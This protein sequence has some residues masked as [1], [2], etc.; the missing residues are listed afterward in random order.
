VTA[1]VQGDV[2]ENGTW[3]REFV[4]HGLAA[5]YVRMVWV[6]RASG[7]S[8]QVQPVVPD[9][10]PEMVFNLGDPVVRLHENGR[11][12]VHPTR[13][14]VGQMTEGTALQT[15]GQVSLA[16]IRLQPWAASAFLNLPA[17]LTVDQI[18]PLDAVMPSGRLATLLRV[19]GE[20]P[21]TIGARLLD[22]VSAYVALLPEPS[23][24]ARSA[25]TVLAAADEPYS[26][27]TLARILGSGER[28]L[29]RVFAGEIGLSPKMVVRIVRTQRAMRLALAH[30][31][32]TWTQVA[33]RSGYHDHAH[34]VRDFR[35]FA[36]QT[37]TAFRAGAGLLTEHLLT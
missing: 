1:E 27:N 18:L 28:R 15:G 13:L 5:R 17:S 35:R 12:E 14:L 21:E 2:G 34:L 37:P 24:L 10:C 32:L 16:G 22:A 6:L 9:G 36:L 29:Q 7:P 31:G 19:D 3:Y 26:V 4:P 33:A 8:G 11:R 30:P 23:G 20:D 25:L